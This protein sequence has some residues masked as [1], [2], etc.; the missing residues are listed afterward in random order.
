MPSVPMSDIM[1]HAEKRII[2]TAPKR[3]EDEVHML[4]GTCI[5]SSC[6]SHKPRGALPM[7]EAPVTNVLSRVASERLVTEV[8]LTLVARAQSC[9][10]TKGRACGGLCVVANGLNNHMCHLLATRRHLAI[11][12][13]V[14]TPSKSSTPPLATPY[15]QL[16][17][18]CI[19]MGTISMLPIWYVC[20]SGLA[21]AIACCIVSD[22]LMLL[23]PLF[24]ARWWLGEMALAICC[25]GHTRQPSFR[26][27]VPSDCKVVAALASNN[28]NWGG[29]LYSLSPHDG[30]QLLQQPSRGWASGWHHHA[31]PTRLVALGHN[32]N[33]CRG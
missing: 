20:G 28:T 8:V 21:V 23:M 7:W 27:K 24:T 26:F 2:I 17:V 6:H 9:V 3:Q 19:G 22:Q 15:A 1:V 16:L 11:P 32:C 18:D 4:S 5:P 29:S 13:V 33:H 31:N 30:L 12:N 10:V 14:A 25:M